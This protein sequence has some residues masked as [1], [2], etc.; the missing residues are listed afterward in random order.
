VFFVGFAVTVNLFSLNKTQML[1]LLGLRAIG[2][3]INVQKIVQMA[4]LTW[5]IAVIFGVRLLYMAIFEWIQYI[6][7]YAW[8]H[9]IN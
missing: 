6:F 5:T 8:H 1:S 3:K 9:F 7:H 2:I 4:D